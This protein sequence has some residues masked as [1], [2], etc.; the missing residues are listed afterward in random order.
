[1]WSVLQAV[2]NTRNGVFT[3]YQPLAGAYDEMV[4]ADG[5]PRP[6]TKRIHAV[7]HSTPPREFAKYQSLAELSLYNQ[8]V[9]F[10]VYSDQQGTEKIFPFCLCRGSRRHRSGPSSSAGW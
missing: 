1:M 7:L 8:G 4:Q 6:H 3:A 10:S 5:T 9:T 2:P